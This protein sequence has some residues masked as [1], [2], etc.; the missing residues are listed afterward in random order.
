MLSNKYN[1]NYSGVPRLC[2][3][4]RMN[5]FRFTRRW[6][7]W[8]IFRFDILFSTIISRTIDNA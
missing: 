8:W 1:L 4:L 6:S 7:F 5:S 3:A 2:Q